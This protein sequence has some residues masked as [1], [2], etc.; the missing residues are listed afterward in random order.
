MYRRA[1]ISTVFA[2][3]S[4]TALGAQSVRTGPTADRCNR[5]GDRDYAQVCETRDFTMPAVKSLA[6][7]GR[8]NGGVSVHG[9]DKAEIQVVATISAHAESEADA[10][11]VAK[12]VT[13][14]ANEGDVHASG[15]RTGR[16]ESWSVSYEVWVP[17]HTNLSLNA[18]NGG[19][20]VDGVDA[21]LDLE[22]V[23]GGLS[24]AD[25]EG[26]VR[27][28]TVNGGITAELSGDRWRG[29]GLDLRTSNGGVR[30]YIPESYSATLETGTQNGRM[31]IGFPITVQGSIRRQ[32]ATQLGAGGATIRA[33]TT[34]GGVSIR[35]R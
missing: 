22:T 24:L 6:I 15:P 27:G 10:A 33:V 3:L 11:E 4:A 29:A 1:T 14:S 26:D 31:D 25:V 5:Y 2:L 16:R 13:I 34:N 21:R 20:T 17:R 19:L 32:I 7:D 9:W 8:D 23:N 18:T 12:Q 35:R 30:L 28:R